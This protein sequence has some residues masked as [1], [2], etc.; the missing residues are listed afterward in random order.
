[1]R[2]TTTPIR[3]LPALVV[4]LAGMLVFAGAAAAA[5]GDRTLRQGMSGDDVMEL[6]REV[7]YLGYPT[8]RYGTFTSRTK[9]DIIHYERKAG[10][11]VNGEASISEQRTSERRAGGSSSSYIFP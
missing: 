6:Q 11:K 3:T 4:A 7:T 2:H 1:M 5:L 10:L 8:P 9:S